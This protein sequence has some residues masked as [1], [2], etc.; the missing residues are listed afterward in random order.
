MSTPRPMPT[1]NLADLLTRRPSTTPAQHPAASPA[2]SPRDAN[3]QPAD[4]AAA[5]VPAATTRA[6]TGPDPEA[7]PT[8]VDRAT[9]VGE[10]REYL[11]SIAL[12]L[13]RTVHQKLGHAAAEL[14]TTRTALI[15]AAV[16]STH[17]HLGPA[18]AT[19]TPPVNSRDLF[20]VPQNKAGVEPSVQTTIR[21][22]DTQHA[23]ITALVA[24]HRTNRSRLVTTALQLHLAMT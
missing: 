17:P 19:P 7:P 22:T 21:V 3:P 15:L 11:R 12:Y 16:N 23:A 10:E 6:A 14:G 1:P 13:P 18:L 5:G 2:T 9:T 20:A 8:P 4:P 24:E